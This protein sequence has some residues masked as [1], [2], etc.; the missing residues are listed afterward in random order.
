M[1]EIRRRPLV[2]PPLTGFYQDFYLMTHLVYALNCFNGHLPNRRSDCPW[3]YSY[4]ERC[5][6]FWLREGKR[7]ERGGK[8]APD[9]VAAQLWETEAVDA[10]AECVDCLLG[11]GEPSDDGP[12]AELVREGCAWLLT[13]QEADGLF[14]SPSVPRSETKE[15]DHLHPT[16]VTCAALQFDRK[17][18]GP[19]P[20]CAAW[21]A[22]IRAA[23]FEVGLAEPPPVPESNL[24]SIPE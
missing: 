8:T 23:A 4:I 15:Y 6:A 3:V 1:A 13:R 5:L 9:V 14:Y 21:A 20:R 17:A 19:S 7:Q 2:E 10:I 22:H 16:W 24:S 11:L 12:L 18:P